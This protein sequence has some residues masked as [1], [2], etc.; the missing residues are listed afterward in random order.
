M[1]ATSILCGPS[2]WEHRD[3]D[4]TVYP[5]PRP[6]SFHPVAFLARRFGMLEIAAT[7]S[8]YIR[9][10]IARLWLAKAGGN[11]TFRFTALVH[12]RFTHD[13]QMEASAMA[14]F[15]DGLAPLLEAGRLGCLVMQ[16]PWPFRFTAENREFFIRLRR[17]LHPFP[18]A[19]QMRHESW[20]SEEARGVFLDYHVAFVNADQ[21][22]RMRVMPPTA[23]LT[24]GFG[25]V[26][27]E[28]RSWDARHGRPRADYR[29]SLE[30]L[31]EWSARLARIRPF[32]E[33][34]YTVFANHSGGRA[35]IDTLQMQSMAGDRLRE[36]EAPS[37]LRAA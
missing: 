2:G 18:V 16:F 37:K 33:R 27:L 29:F 12:R 10:E 20:M 1:S 22:Q 8:T 35:A 13:R 25:Y 15:R 23:F 34:I 26:R 24:A 36:A 28:G 21:P 31:A 30:D 9:P 11:R 14:R 19:A 17:E 7:A 3:W 4:G 32:A 6:L 5:R